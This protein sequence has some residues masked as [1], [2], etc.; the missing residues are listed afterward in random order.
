MKTKQT[1]R[2]SRDANDEQASAQHTLNKQQ[3][4]EIDGSVA[5]SFVVRASERRVCLRLHAFFP[6]A[7]F[8]SC[9]STDAFYTVFS[10]CFSLSLS[11]FF[12]QK[13]KKK[14]NPTPFVII[15]RALQYVAPGQ[16]LYGNNGPPIWSPGSSDGILHSLKIQAPLF[17][18]SLFCNSPIIPSGYHKR[19]NCLL[20]LTKMEGP[21]LLFVKP[22]KPLLYTL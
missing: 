7:L 1:I 21:P 16:V 13:K 18:F 12:G 19:T 2:D 11:F 9:K 8:S 4:H 3:K 6:F 20:D 14:K 10:S 22:G 5:E 15:V 17:F